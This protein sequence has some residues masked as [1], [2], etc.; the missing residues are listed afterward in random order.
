[1]VPPLDLVSSGFQLMKSD[2]GRGA[3]LS[4]TVAKHSTT[5]SR[6]KWKFPK[7]QAVACLVILI[8]VGVFLYP[9][10][11]SWFSQKE[12]SRVTEMA[13][14]Q[15]DLP[16]NDDQAYRTERIAE[17]HRYNDA[18]AS[19]ALLQANANVPVGDGT[20]SDESLDY[21]TILDITDNGFMGRLK[22]D[23]LA[24][25]LP[26]YHGTSDDTLA[27]GIGHLEGTSLPVGGIGT[28]TVLTAHRGL[29]TATLFNELDRAEVGDTFTVAVLDQ[30]L[31]YRVIETRVI[32]P[33]DTEAVLA[34]RDRD[35]ATLIT[36]TPLGIN[37]HR[38]LVT[39][40]RITPTPVGDVV[41]ATAVPELPGFPW[42]AVWL[43]LTVILLATYIWRVGYPPKARAKE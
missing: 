28:R 9:S 1:M 13:Q 25:D 5:S 29:P 35:L 41:A 24:I 8:G 37:S 23:A 20:S 19:G 27:R 3:E 14:A 17:A 18:L 26:I 10:V 30:V 39:A 43:G 33:G 11:A 40:E 16:P 6:P 21:N 12:Q 15:L 7:L 2:R 36:C 38:I 34:D 4:T 22:Y 32:D 42:W 31:T